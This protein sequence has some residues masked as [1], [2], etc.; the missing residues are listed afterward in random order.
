MRYS[1]ADLKSKLRQLKKLEIKLR[2]R[3][4]PIPA[5]CSLIWNDFFSTKDLEDPSVRFPLSVLLDMDRSQRKEAF[6]EYFYWVYYQHFRENGLTPAGLYDPH[7]LS[8]L[9]LPAYAGIRDIKRRFRKLAKKYHPDHGGDAEQF[10]A[11]IEVYERL[12]DRP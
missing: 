6:G 12:T 10:I 2:F 9:G 4:G 11:M 5:T 1:V 8:L 7:L 3:G